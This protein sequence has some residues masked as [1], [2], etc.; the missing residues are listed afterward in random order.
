MTAVSQSAVQLQITDDHK[1]FNNIILR[2]GR[3]VGSGGG[4]LNL[5]CFVQNPEAC[6]AGLPERS[7]KEQN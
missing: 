2:G 1:H 4:A 5:L 3:W 7:R 6:I